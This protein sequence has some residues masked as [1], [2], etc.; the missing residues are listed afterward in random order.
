M[1]LSSPPSPGTKQILVNDLT[2]N[3]KIRSIAAY[4]HKLDENSR[5]KRKLFGGI[6]AEMFY[7]ECESDEKSLRM[8]TSTIGG[9]KFAFDTWTTYFVSNQVILQTYLVD[10]IFRNVVVD[11]YLFV[12]AMCG[13]GSFT[14]PFVDR[15]VEKEL[16]FNL[17]ANDL[18]PEAIKYLLQNLTTNISKSA[19]VSGSRQFPIG[20]TIQ[21]AETL[22]RKMCYKSKKT[23]WVILAGIPGKTEEELLPMFFDRELYAKVG[24]VVVTVTSQRR[25][26]VRKVLERASREW[27]SDVGYKFDEPIKHVCV[28]KEKIECHTITFTLN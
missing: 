17:L 26:I 28:N 16:S 3:A 5:I 7:S 14:V 12:D 8:C 13:I 24:K 21:D 18:N 19:I 6:E 25:R 4:Y 22:I 10:E 9:L 27:S 15:A 20:S 2:K 23:V 11:D 1:G